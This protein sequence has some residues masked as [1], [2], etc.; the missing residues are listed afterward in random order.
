MNESTFQA[1]SCVLS[2]QSGSWYLRMASSWLVVMFELQSL[3]MLSL[4]RAALVIPG[5]TTLNTH[6]H[7]IIITMTTMTTCLM[8]TWPMLTSLRL[9]PPLIC[10]YRASTWPGLSLAL[11]R[12]T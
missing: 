9:V 6:Y 5:G 12:F 2:K 1:F 11:N 8:S 4:L 3:A 7:H 10:V